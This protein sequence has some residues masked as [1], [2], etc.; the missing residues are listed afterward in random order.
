L[1]LHQDMRG[2]MEGP[3]QREMQSVMQRL[4]QTEQA[5]EQLNITLDSFWEEVAAISDLSTEMQ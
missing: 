4:Q 5:L 2:Q 1:Q 3:H